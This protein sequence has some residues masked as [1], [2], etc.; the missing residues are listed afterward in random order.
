MQY[1]HRVVAPKPNDLMEKK[2]NSD[3]NWIFRMRSEVLKAVNTP[4]LFWAVTSCGL[5][6]KILENSTVSIF[7]P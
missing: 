7:L 2:K 1:L 3:N 6:T 5:D 4:M